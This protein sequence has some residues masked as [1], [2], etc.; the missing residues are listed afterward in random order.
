MKRKKI[1]ILTLTFVMLLLTA[2]GAGKENVENNTDNTENSVEE[3]ANFDE[4]SEE[5][6]YGTDFSSTW[7]DLYIWNC[8]E[9]P[10]G[11]LSDVQRSMILYPKFNRENICYDPET[12]YYHSVRWCYMLE[13]ASSI[14]YCNLSYATEHK[15]QPCD[16]CIKPIK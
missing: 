8:G 14:E 4:S 2:C 1:V 9:L 13:D 6:E 7:G 5:P 15:M 3:N 12:N 10:R 11:N 16:K